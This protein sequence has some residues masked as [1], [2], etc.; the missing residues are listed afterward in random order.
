MIIKKRELRKLI[1]EEILKENRLGRE[2]EK[3]MEALKLALKGPYGMSGLKL[4]MMLY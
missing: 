3:Q 2:A 4:L 1:K